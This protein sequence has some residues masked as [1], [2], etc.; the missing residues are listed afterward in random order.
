MPRAL[1]WPARNQTRQQSEQPFNLFLPTRLVPSQRSLARRAQR[2]A[3][4]DHPWVH[5]GLAALAVAVLGIGTAG[6]IVATGNAERPIAGAVQPAVER[7]AVERSVTAGVPRPQAFSRESAARSA[8]GAAPERPTRDAAR[9]ALPPASVGS[10]VRARS[11]E[12]AQ[13]AAVTQKRAAALAAEQKKKRAAL[14]AEQKKQRAALAAKRKKELAAERERRKQLVGNGRAVLPVAG[15]RM[16]AGFGA[17]GAWARYHTGIDYSAGH[18]TSIRAPRAGVVTVA[19][20][21]QASGWAGTYVAIKHSDGT[22]SL[23]AHMSSVSVSTGERVDAGRLVGQVGQTGRAFGPH[24]HFEIY[25][26]GVEPGDV[27]NAV[28]PK[29]WL[30]DLG[31]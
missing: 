28:D 19:G 16:A 27:Y 2:A 10:A 14:A 26:A 22:S 7:P 1:P 5:R 4:S 6:S 17:T 31:L 15:A 13:K 30:D 12:L 11:V 25:P 23:Y 24:L 3:T 20:N 8:T 21:G 18:G 29:P 9:E